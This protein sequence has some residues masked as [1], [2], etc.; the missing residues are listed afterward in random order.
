MKPNREKKNESVCYRCVNY[1]ICP[2]SLEESKVFYC[3]WFWDGKVS[4]PH[5]DDEE[6]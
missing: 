6:L 3:R 2:L 5:R 1:F 4:R